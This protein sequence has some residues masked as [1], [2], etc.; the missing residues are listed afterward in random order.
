MANLS[1]ASEIR[2]Q[3]LGL[4]TIKVM[5]WGAHNWQ[6]GDNFLIFTV[7][8][9]HFKGK[10]KITL[11]PMD[12][13]EIEFFKPRKVEAEKKFEGVYFDQM[14]DLIDGYVEYIPEYK[15]R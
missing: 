12:E 13:Y 4:G 2:N 6:G 7:S 1:I 9:R 15:D 10:V 5:T 14:V 3:L 11:T 8:G